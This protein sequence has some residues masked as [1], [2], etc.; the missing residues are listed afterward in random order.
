MSRLRRGPA[1]AVYAALALVLAVAGIGLAFARVSPSAQTAA[2]AETF[3]VD[4]VAWLED[5]PAGERIFNRYEWGGYLGLRLPDRPIFID[6]RAD[7]YDDEILLE[8]VDAISVVGDPQ[9]VFDR[10]GI[11]HVLYPADST[12]GRWLN[13]SDDWEVVYADDVASVWAASR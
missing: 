3:P 12:L 5:N 11:D 2:V 6:G 7:V 1:G 4:A 9:D 13:E 10:Y 8:Y